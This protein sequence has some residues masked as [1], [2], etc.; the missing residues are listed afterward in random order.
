MLGIGIGGFV[1]GMVRGYGLREDMKDRELARE[2]R[3]EDRKYRAEEMQFRREDRAFQREDREFAR[4]ERNREVGNR[5]RLESIQTDARERFEEGVEKG[6]YDSGEFE[7]FWTEYALPKY[8]AELI[9]QNDI[10]GATAL[11]DWS[12]TQGAK[13]GR[14]LFGQAMGA[15]QTGDYAGALDS[16]I[17]AG[18]VQ[19]YIGNGFEI[20]EKEEIT[21]EDGTLLG[22]RVTMT[23]GA[24]NEN[25]QDIAI[26]DVPTFVSRF[27]NPTAAFE[28]QQATQA[29]QV[30][31]EED[32]ADYRTK[33]EIDAEFDN[34]A[35][36]KSRADAI[37]ALR[38]S[39]PGD[40][41]DESIASFDKMDRAEQERMIAEEIALQSGGGV[42]A[43][44][45]AGRVVVDTQTGQ[46]VPAA[47]PTADATGLGESTK[48]AQRAPAGGPGLGIGPAPSQRP[49]PVING[50]PD[51]G[52]ASPPSAAESV[53]MAAQEMVSGGNPQ[54]IA[55]R[56]TALQI[57]Q[58]KWPSSITQAL[59]QTAH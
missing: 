13:R 5:N 26:E 17:E 44:P 40:P 31:R 32:M 10:E 11:A 53:N 29:R 38:K 35:G 36:G 22:Y 30:E 23:D 21:D 37:T 59:Q 46:P 55:K 41:Y 2:E 58:S 15:A 8:Q 12:A 24:G 9:L 3:A 47:Q 49:A 18:K 50:A 14:Q 39:M 27:A 48:P 34:E 56:L 57:P 45:P 7:K 4:S 1:E 54:E 20:S 52:I 42:A 19:G 33:A 16:A 6:K 43:T 25:Q 28:S 51:T